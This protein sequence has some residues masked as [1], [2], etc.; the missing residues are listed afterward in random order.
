MKRIGVDVGG[1]FADAYI[2]T[3]MALDA[4]GAVIGARTNELGRAATETPRAQRGA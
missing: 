2:T 4:H 3:E 1:T